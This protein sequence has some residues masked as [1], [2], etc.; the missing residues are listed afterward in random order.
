MY[1][2]VLLV[3][4]QFSF[5]S[6][7][8]VGLD[9][10]GYSYDPT[11]FTLSQ[12]PLIPDDA[13]SPSLPSVKNVESFLL[14]PT[15][16]AFVETFTQLVKSSNVLS[17]VFDQSETTGYRF[18]RFLYK[19][20]RMQFINYGSPYPE[21][22][23]EICTLP[24]AQNFPNLP[25]QIMINAYGYTMARLLL[26]EKIL[27]ESNA[28]MLA[29]DF[30]KSFEDIAERQSRSQSDFEFWVL[31][32]GFRNFTIS[33][34]AMTPRKG[35]RLAIYCAVTWMLNA[36]LYWPGFK[37]GPGII[38][39]TRASFPSGNILPPVLPSANNVEAFLLG[40]AATTFVQVL[41]KEVKSSN[42]LTEI[43]DLSQTTGP[44]YDQFLYKSCLELLKSY[45]TKFPEVAAGIG[46]RPVA[47]NFPRLSLQIMVTQYGYAVARFLLSEKRLNPSNAEDLALAYVKSFADSAEFIS[48][49][50]NDYQFRVIAKGFNNFIISQVEMT[51]AKGWRLAIYCGVTWMLNAVLYGS[52]TFSVKF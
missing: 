40:P 48:R 6:F 1:F 2:F 17:Q 19:S 12:I 9:V 13:L 41:M 11:A 44:Q 7:K 18:Y 8:V 15:A 21:V 51:S 26:S 5:N 14:G 34:I 24:I 39:L 47:Q 52:E 43:F 35:W 30:A 3:I 23:A 42:T 25:L 16:V 37:Y 38:T 31:S 49:N 50:Q 4:F 45:G 27:N 29:L 46:T 20:C 28:E 22:A 32:K 36:V 33:Q 10:S